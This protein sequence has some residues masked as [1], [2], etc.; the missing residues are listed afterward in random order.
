[1]TKTLQDLFNT[2]PQTGE[3]MWIGLR[4]A[5]R[6]ELNSVE[7][8]QVN[9]EQGLVGDH[10]GK[11]GGKRQVTLILHEHLAVIGSCLGRQSVDPALLRR[12][13]VVR[14]INLL[15]LKDQQ[16]KI[17]TAVL[18]M[19][20]YCHPCSLMEEQFGAGGYN[21]VRGHG[22]ITAQVVQ[23]GCISLGNIVTLYQ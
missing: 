16:F 1:M 3:V 22:G 18:E 2:L 19:T 14:G 12:N 5:R 13:I 6:A 7:S 21:A 17:G 9:C 8:V 20:D 23:P 10:Y 15:A 4:P 11:V